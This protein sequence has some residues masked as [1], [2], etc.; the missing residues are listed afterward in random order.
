[1]LIRDEPGHS[2]A[3][4]TCRENTRTY[5]KIDL[6]LNAIMEL[7]NPSFWRN[8]LCENLGIAQLQDKRPRKI[9]PV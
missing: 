3:C 1:M 9:R 7:N 2:P 8:R 5:I 6:L 4:G